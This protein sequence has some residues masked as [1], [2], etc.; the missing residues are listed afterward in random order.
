M[1]SQKLGHMT[2]R[3]LRA[4]ANATPADLVAGIA[5]YDRARDAA[6]AILP[7]DPNRAAGV[8]AALSPR[9]QWATNVAWAARMIDA[10]QA[11][12]ACPP[13]VHT[14]TQRRIAWAIANGADPLDVL[15]GPKVRRF[16]LNI[17]GDHNVVT[18]DVWA[19]RAAEGHSNPAAP[20]GGRY[21]AIERAYQNAARVVGMTPRDLQAAVWVHTRGSAA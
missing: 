11:G 4:H 8:I 9:C 13:R 18:V 2:R 17:I 19:A 3:I 14:T 1:T 16:Y 12:E 10:A 20:R 5:W 15:S 6:A 21:D 7:D